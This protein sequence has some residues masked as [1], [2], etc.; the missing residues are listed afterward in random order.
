MQLRG[1]STD[2]NRRPSEAPLLAALPRRSQAPR[3][4]VLTRGSRNENG[5][6][7]TEARIWAIAKRFF[8]YAAGE[9]RP[10]DRALADKLVRASPHW[11]R[12]TH[13]TH[14]LARGASLIAVRDNL[15]HSSLQTTSR[16]AHSEDETRAEEMAKAF[17]GRRRG[18]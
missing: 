8:V 13:G 16:Y 9:V 12:H 4:W 5:A 11:M 17:P 10:R 6:P 1:I 3:G 18:G 7:L 2:P 15:R 14:A